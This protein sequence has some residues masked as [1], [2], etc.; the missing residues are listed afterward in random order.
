MA[1]YYINDESGNWVG[2]RIYHDARAAIPGAKRAVAAS[3]KRGIDRALVVIV[4][5][6]AAFGR[7]VARVTRAGVEMAKG[8]PA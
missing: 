3:A 6:G 1:N 5:D 4:S 8:E 7:K 2:N